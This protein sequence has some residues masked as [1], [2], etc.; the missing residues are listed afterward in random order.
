MHR[1]PDARWHV[2]EHRGDLPFEEQSRKWQPAA[3]LQGDTGRA[4]A[5]GQQKG[6]VLR[7]AAMK[8][9]A[10]LTLARTFGRTCKV[11]RRK[12]ALARAVSEKL[13]VLS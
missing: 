13:G 3:D 5:G 1:T 8:G 10:P 12:A 2:P 9:L 7:S 4:G 11:R 6:G